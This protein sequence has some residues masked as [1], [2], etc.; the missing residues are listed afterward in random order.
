MDRNRVNTYM[1]I[2]MGPAGKLLEIIQ[3]NCPNLIRNSVKELVSIMKDKLLPLWREFKK[4][5]CEKS[6]TFSVRFTFLDVCEILLDRKK[7]ERSGNWPLHLHATAS[8]LPFLR[9]A[10]RTHY[11]RW[12]PI[13][14]L[15]MLDLPE[16]VEESFTKGQ[17]SVRETGNSLNGIWSDMSVEKTIVRDAKSESGIKQ[18]T[19]SALV[20]WAITRQK[21]EV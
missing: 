16:D 4:A 2:I 15:D 18:Q 3:S 19:E 14:T 7:A 8:M 21:I 6:P 9:A 17:F 11:S 20:R 13:Y 1:S 5:K 12:L 10:N